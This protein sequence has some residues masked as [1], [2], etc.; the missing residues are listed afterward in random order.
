MSLIVDP[1]RLQNWSDMTG[2]YVRAQ[3]PDGTTGNADIATLTTASLRAWLAS[4]PNIATNVVLIL[5]HHKKD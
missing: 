1:A 5:L 3:F 2:I 4:A